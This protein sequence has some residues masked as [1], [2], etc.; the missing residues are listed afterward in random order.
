MAFALVNFI[1]NNYEIYYDLVAVPSEKDPWAKRAKN[2]FERLALLNTKESRK[3]T[4]G[5]DRAMYFQFKEM[6]SAQP[7]FR[8][9][10]DEEKQKITETLAI[11]YGV[12]YAGYMKA[13]DEEDEII[14]RAGT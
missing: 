5:E 6:L 14:N 3:I 4:P 8:K 1:A 11:M 2:S 10:T 12:L 7:R 9:M 13:I